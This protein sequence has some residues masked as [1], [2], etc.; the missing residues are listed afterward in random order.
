MSRR[1]LYIVEDDFLRVVSF[2]KS[3]CVI[4][5][6]PDPIV[7]SSLR[8]LHALMFSLVFW[9][10][11]L[12]RIP[13]HSRVFLHEIGSDAIQILPQAMMGFTKPT[14]LLIRGIVENTLRY[15]YFFDH[16]VEFAR[17]NRE[18]KWFL[19]TEELFAYPFVHPRM[20]DLKAGFTPIDRLKTLYD[21]LSSIVHGRTVDRLEM[22]RALVQIRYNQTSM[23]TI[24]DWAK[25]CT[26]SSNF[27][28][29]TF[30]IDQFRNFDQTTRR[31]LVLTMPSIARR[32]LTGLK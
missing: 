18:K 16:P 13:S 4:P 27:L 7:L 26:E 9:R 8:Q 10:F 22:Q 6:N 5:D 2:L 20:V 3:K 11:R 21:D 15:I 30:H 14:C 12:K 23:D 28:L 17:M 32:Q 1:K 25:R 31:V 19:T 29:A 24:L